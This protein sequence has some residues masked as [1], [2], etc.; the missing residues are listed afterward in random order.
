MGRRTHIGGGTA[1]LLL[2]GLLAWTASVRQRAELLELGDAVAHRE[3]EIRWLKEERALLQYE[4]SSVTD[5][6][7]T[8][9]RA[10]E[11]GMSRPRDDQILYGHACF[12]DRVEITAREEAP[13]L[14][15]LR[16]TAEKIGHI[17]GERG[18]GF[19]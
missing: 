17:F 14:R 9:R 3:E 10:R 13:W 15:R 7:E 5:L 1:L 4:R 16:E 11:L 6:E 12:P 2:L 8:E 19:D 18:I